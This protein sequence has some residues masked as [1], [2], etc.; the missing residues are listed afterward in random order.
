MFGFPQKQSGACRLFEKH[1]PKGSRAGERGESNQFI[2]LYQV[3]GH[4]G[5]RSFIPW[6][7]SEKWCRVH[8]PEF[9]CPRGN[10]AEVFIH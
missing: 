2:V 5:V 6:I 7:N 8:T 3:S 9:L 10:R 1:E 4:V